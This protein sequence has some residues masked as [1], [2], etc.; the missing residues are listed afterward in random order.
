MAAV[1]RLSQLGIGTAAYR[2][3]R[4]AAAVE[5]EPQAPFIGFPLIVPM[6]VEGHAYGVLPSFIGRA[7]GTV[8][9]A[10][11]AFGRLPRLMGEAHGSVGVAGHTFAKLP[12]LRGEARGEFEHAWPNDDDLAILWLIAA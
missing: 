11:R 4:T 3:P 5:A 8:G 12:P 10:G 9:V 2:F 6:P 7:Y 1:T